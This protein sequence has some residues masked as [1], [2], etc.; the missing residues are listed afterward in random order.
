MSATK[1]T[2]FALKVKSFFVKH[3]IIHKF[4]ISCCKNQMSLNLLINKF[5]YNTSIYSTAAKKNYH[6][7]TSSETA[8]T[9]HTMLI[10]LPK[11]RFFLSCSISFFELHF[12]MPAMEIGIAGR[13]IRSTANLN[14][15]RINATNAVPMACSPDVSDRFLCIT[16]ATITFTS[17]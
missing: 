3:F 14:K 5:Y 16:I 6:K 10:F 7:N 15:I 2:S 8:V 9:R 12:T 17:V 1:R 13:K 4:K 11:S